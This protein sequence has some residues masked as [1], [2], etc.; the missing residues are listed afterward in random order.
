MRHG[1]SAAVGDAAVGPGRERAQGGAIVA[2]VPLRVDQAT[3]RL[4]LWALA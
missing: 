4:W 3:S 1:G 2:G